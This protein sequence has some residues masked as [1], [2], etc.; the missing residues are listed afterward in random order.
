M[1]KKFARYARLIESLRDEFGLFYAA[2][3]CS[4]ESSIDDVVCLLI[5]SLLGGRVSPHSLQKA[6]AF[7]MILTCSTKKLKIQILAES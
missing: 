3:S 4:V 2:L 5:D 6:V 1:N 7:N